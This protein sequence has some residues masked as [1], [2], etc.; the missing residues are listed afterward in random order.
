[1]SQPIHV[2]V[3]LD[4][5]M[6]G[7]NGGSGTANDLKVGLGQSDVVYTSYTHFTRVEGLFVDR[8]RECT[9]ASRFCSVEAKEIEIAFAYFESQ[10]ARADT[11]IE[12]AHKRL[13]VVSKC[14]C[15]E[16]SFDARDSFSGKRE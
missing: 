9:G 16:P 4:G 3:D 6:L 11:V 10:V 7:A 1:M 14:T 5:D 8:S 15:S 12:R 13:C 2:S